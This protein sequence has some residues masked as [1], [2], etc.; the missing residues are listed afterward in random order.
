MRFFRFQYFIIVLLLLSVQLCFAREVI[1]SELVTLTATASDTDCDYTDPDCTKTV[2]D[3]IPSG[4]I[5]WSDD[6]GR[7]T[8]VSFPSGNT[9]TSVQWLA[10]S[11]SGSVSVTVTAD[12]SSSSKYPDASASDSETIVVS[13]ETCYEINDMDD[14]QECK[15]SSTEHLEQNDQDHQIDGCSI[16]YLL[17]DILGAYTRDN[18]TGCNDPSTT[19]F[20][21]CEAHDYCYQTCDSNFVACNLGMKGGM[22]DVCLGD[23]IYGCDEPGRGLEGI[24]NWYNRCNSYKNAYYYGIRDFGH[25]AWEERQVGYCECCED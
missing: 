13:C 6:T 23:I 19:F 12:N 18:P 7:A 8:G 4:S 20:Y 24:T 5:T 14:W 15:D 10:P 21:A 16:P 11:T 1:C 17:A 22:E 25:G 9:G 2:T 3:S